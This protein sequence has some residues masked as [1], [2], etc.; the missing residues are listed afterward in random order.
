MK[1]ILYFVRE[2]E[3]FLTIFEKNWNCNVNIFLKKYFPLF[4]VN[5]KGIMKGQPHSRRAHK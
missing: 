4:F 5:N 1:L 2:V 3:I